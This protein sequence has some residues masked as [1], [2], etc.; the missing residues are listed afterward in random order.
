ML[1]MSTFVLFYSS[2]Q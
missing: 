2:C 1:L